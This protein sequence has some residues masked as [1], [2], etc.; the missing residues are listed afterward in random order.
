MSELEALRRERAA[1]E[2]AARAAAE[3]ARV[4]EMRAI[5]LDAAAYAI[6]NAWKGMR[7][8]RA[9]EA[10]ATGKGSKA[11]GGKASTKK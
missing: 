8:R 5:R 10:K 3:A 6:Q 9:A 2:A 4:A 7:K 1:H 11:K